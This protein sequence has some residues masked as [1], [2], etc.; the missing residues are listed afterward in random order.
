M[1]V[2]MLSALV[3]AH[4]DADVTQALALARGRTA[5]R[6]PELM[7]DRGR[8]VMELSNAEVD[9][10]EAAVEQSSQVEMANIDPLSFRLPTL[11]SK[12]RAIKEELCEGCGVFLLRNLPV[13]R[14]GV[15]K[16][17]RAFWLIGLGL[18]NTIP[19]PQNHKGHLLGHVRDLGNDPNLPETRIYTTSAA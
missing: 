3:A 1:L 17:A 10:L 16:S 19:V 6:A 5:W 13:E 7:A 18:G 4:V 11:T 2:L 9:E 12:L 14:W 8:W 15:E